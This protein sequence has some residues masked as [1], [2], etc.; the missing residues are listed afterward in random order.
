MKLYVARHGQ[1]DY[2]RQKKFYGA[3]DVS[4]NETGLADANRLAVKCQG[5]PLDLIAISDLKRA[6]QTA[7][8]IIKQH[9]NSRIQQFAQLE[10]LH[11]G[12][13][14]GLNADEIQQKYPLDWQRWLED[15]FGVPPTNGEN[16]QDFRARVLSALEKILVGSAPN[17]E[18]LV[19]AHLGVLRVINQFFFPET[20]FWQ[21]K[22]VA[23]TYSIYEVDENGACVGVTYEV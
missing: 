23:G 11:F 21:P 13:W 9:P 17:D 4:L 8:L 22:F 2:N 12:A 3:A 14:E 20:A 15:P 1:T 18:V 5:L 6:R 7:R 16:F 10:E 19:I